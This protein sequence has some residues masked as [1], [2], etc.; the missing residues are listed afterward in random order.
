MIV[1][2]LMIVMRILMI[3]ITISD[4]FS[5]VIKPPALNFFPVYIQISSRICLS[6]FRRSTMSSVHDRHAAARNASASHSLYHL[7]LIFAF[8][9]V[10]AY[11]YSDMS[12]SKTME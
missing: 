10:N 11:L 8:L 5:F 3:I 4:H 7:Y 2:K 1:R 6:G 9:I 12:F